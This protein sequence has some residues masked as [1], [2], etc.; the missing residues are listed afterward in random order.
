MVFAG[1]MKDSIRN[2][3]V[4]SSVFSRRMS[5][6]T[7]YTRMAIPQRGSDACVYSN[8]TMS[9]TSKL[10]SCVK[11]LIPDGRSRIEVTE[12]PTFYGSGRFSL[13]LLQ[14]GARQCKRRL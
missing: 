6:T 13:L 10:I 9:E 4:N 2:T 11:K 14:S 1:I 3:R 12:S 7:T 8:H 5:V